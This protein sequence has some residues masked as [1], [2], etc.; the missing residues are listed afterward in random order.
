MSKPI[1]DNKVHKNLPTPKDSKPF[2]KPALQSKRSMDQPLDT[3]ESKNEKEADAVA[4]RVMKTPEPAIPISQSA[5]NI[6]RQ[7]KS[8]EANEKSDGVVTE[9]AG[10]VWSQLNKNPEFELWKKDQ[11]TKLKYKLWDSQ[12]TEL[13]AGVVGFG[14]S[15]VGLLGTA[16]AIDPSFRAKSIETLQG[17]NLALPLSLLPHSEYLGLSGFKYN[18]PSAENAQY[19]FASE[20]SLTPFLELLR[21]K[22]EFPKVG[23]DL[24][25]DSSYSKA[26]GFKP[27]T[28]GNIKLKFG[29]GIVDVSAFY[30][31]TLPATPVLINNPNL[32][33]PPVWL[34]RSLPSQM[35]DNLP[36]GTGVFIT[37]D[38][39]RLPELFNSNQSKTKQ[40]V[41]RKAKDNSNNSGFAPPIVSEVLSSGK[42]AQLESG[43]RQFM[44]N[45]F[46]QD[47]S[48]VR[49]HTGD[50]A[51]Q[52]A[53]AIHANAYTSGNNI[54][55]GNGKFQPSNESGKNLLAHELVHVIQQSESV[56]RKEIET[57]AKPT[58]VDEL[59]T[60]L[61]AGNY[62]GAWLQLNDLLS[63]GTLVEK[64]AWLA[65]HPDIRKLFLNQLPANIVA[66]V[67][68]AEE[69][70]MKTS[71][72]SFSLIDCW[73]QTEGEKE[74]LFSQ[75]LPLF[76]HLLNYISP[77][78]G[79]PIKE[80]VEELTKT[81]ENK[82]YRSS[83]NNKEFHRIHLLAP[84]VERKLK[85]Y[86][87][88]EKL[89][90][91]VAKNFDPYT[92]IRM[93][94]ME[95]LTD[96]NEIDRKQAL[97]IYEQLKVLPEEQRKAFID[98]T[99][100]SGAVEA[101]KDAE[102][103]YKKNY[104]AQYKALPHNWD[105]AILPWNWSKWDAPF[106][107]RLTI[108][109]V[110]LMS[111]ALNYEDKATRKFGFDRG[112]AT[113]TNP[114]GGKIK[115]DAERL[116]I[117]I[118]DTNNFNDPQRL[119]LLLAIA[120]RGG[121]EKRVTDRI[122]KP[123]NEAGE[124]SPSIVPLLESY[125][126]VADDGFR[127][128]DDKALHAKHKSSQTWYVVKKTLFGGKAGKV[129]GEQRGTFDLRKL[130]D[131]ADNKGALGGMKIG[132]QTH[133]RE[134]YYNNKWLENQVKE[135]GASDTLLPNL[136][137]T[138]GSARTGKIFA[139][140]HNKNKQ[141]NIYASNI[142]LEGLNYFAGGT[143]YRSGPGVLQGL[144]INLSWTKDTKDP[145]NSISLRLNID[146]IQ[147]NNFQ[148]IASKSTLAI[149]HIGMKGFR[150]SLSQKNLPAAKGLFI[151]LFKNADFMLKALMGLMPNALKLLPYA[152][153]T[154]TEEFKGAK[155]HAY[156]DALGDLMKENF[157]SFKSS[158][159]F[160]SL[161]VKNL[162][163]TT[164]GFLDDF[165]IAQK[166]KDNELIR[167]GFLVKETWQWTIDAT[168]NIKKRIK[169]LERKLRAEKAEL[170]GSDS[171][172]QLNA[173]EDEKIKLLE[174][175]TEK[176]LK[177]QNRDAEMNRLRE[178]IS[179]TRRLSKELD[180]QFEKAKVDNPLYSPLTFKVLTAEI[181]RLQEDLNYLDNT[182]QKDKQIAEGK[183]GGAKRFEARER[184]AA[185]EAKYKSF[186]VD[187][188]L[189]GV[190]L[191]GG[192]YVRDI[193]NDSLVS[194]GF[195]N[196]SLEGVENINIGAVDSA[197]TVS[198]KGASSKGDKPGLSIRK[199]KIPLIKAPALSYKTSGMWI[200]AGTPQLQNVAVS[201]R[202]DFEENP[203]EKD[204]QSQYKYKLEKLTVAYASFTGLTLKMGKAAP[205]LNFKAPTP[206]EVWGLQF[207]NFDPELGNINMKIRD[208]KAEG[209]YED[210]DS[211]KKN[212]Q[213]IEFGI[214][215][216]ID[217]ETD[218]GRK[219]AI[220]I[221]YNQKEESIHTLLNIPS[222][223]LPA[224]NLQ[225]PTMD[226]SSMPN[227]QAVELKNIHADVKVMMEQKES[228][229]E[230]VRPASVEIKNL[231]I[232]E[233]LAKGIKVL[234]RED[235]DKV[236]D[237]EKDQNDNEKVQEVILP[238]E[239]QVSIR[240]IQ[241]SGL[242]LTFEEQGISLST[243]EK[244]ATIKLGQSDLSGIEFK[245]RSAKG[246]ILRAVSVHRG[247]FDALTLEAL[248]RN[249]RTYTL[250]EFF[251]FFGRSRL[252]D[253][254]GNLSYS[255]GKRSGTI[256]LS[257]K[258]N[259]A[260]SIDYHE[261]EEGKSGYYSM[262]LP[263][264]RI[265]VPALHIEMGAHVINIP[266]PV[267]KTKV[268]TLNDVDVKLRAFVEFPD[269]DKVAYDIFLDSLD[270]AN[271]SV[272]GLE[273]HHKSK[274]ID[275]VFE[276][277][278]PL[279]IPNVKAGGF[280]FSSAKGFDVFG[281]AGCWASAA[282]GTESIAASLKS[283]QARI[284]DGG[285]LAEADA[286]KSA[287]SL[288]IESMGFSR[289]KAGN[290]TIGLGKIQG[291]FPKM[292]ITQTDATTGTKTE[293]SIASME[294][295]LEAERV[296]VN[297]GADKNHLIDLTG[298]TAGGLKIE[299]KETKGKEVSTTTVKIAEKALGAKSAQVKLNADKS[300]EITLSE[301]TGGEI[302]ADL[303]SKDLKEKSEK[304][305]RL[306]DPALI[307]VEAVNIKI[308]PEGNKRITI[309]KPTIRNFNLRVPSQEKSGDFTSIRCDL[310]VDG[311]MEM[312]DGIFSTMTLGEPS[313]AFVVHVSGNV[314]VQIKNL[315]LDYKD[316]SSSK[317][318]EEE[319]PKPLNQAQKKLLDLEEKLEVARKH[320]TNTPYEYYHGEHSFPNPEWPKA[321]AAV[322]A[323]EKAFETQ[324]S[325]IIGAARGKAQ[326]SMT[327][328]YLDAVQGEIQADMIA[329]DTVIPINIETFKG[330]KYLE[331]SN[332]VV[333]SLKSLIT[334]ILK[335]TVDKDFWSS[336]DMKAI[337]KGLKR[338]Y[339]L[340]TPYTRGLINAIADG[341]GF[342]AIMVF[343]EKTSIEKGILRDDPT[344]F[345]LN[346]NI[347]TSYGL[348]ISGYDKF[349]IGLCE[350]KYKHP[351]KDNYY[352]LY[353]FVEYLGYISPALVSLTGQQDAKRAKRLNEGINRTEKELS[354][355][356]IG[357][358]V[359]EMIAFIQ[360]SLGQE[361]ENL[362]NTI[363]RNIKG[364]GFSAD[365]S[366]TPQEVIKE[367]L[368]EKK[369][370]TFTF[371]KGDNSIDDLYIKGGYLNRI[372]PKALLKLGGGTAG[373]ENISIPG[374]TY[375]SQKKTTKVSY[376][377]LEVSPLFLSYESEK[378]NLI[379]KNIKLLGLKLAVKK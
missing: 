4:K 302:S 235:P 280:R 13:K 79:E 36:K 126:F 190:S 71:V 117:Q 297:L 73:Y 260:I 244:D 2:F 219:N 139:S 357:E 61:E 202:I 242:K 347:N 334:S 48:Q 232:G 308:D 3:E 339:T 228:L 113:K 265:N 188:A 254:D 98:V 261:L 133:E 86:K 121:L 331:I 129:I 233:I 183:K 89:F 292:T 270:I 94:T 69:L 330:E 321:Y 243:L 198:G 284:T 250:K 213:K 41:Q 215:T 300:K 197:Y 229:N 222:V 341:N 320:L 81:I 238:K 114:E 195:I 337:G 338:W 158:L 84:S 351:D 56:Q 185:I 67:Y 62:A 304:N 125:G 72:A 32:G 115:N 256:G 6:Q 14:L 46:G 315:V 309:I 29:A 313:D 217:N 345:G 93:R 360:F 122:L 107:E 194:M 28:G 203:L 161:S 127:Y 166:N 209:L 169:T 25:L 174:I 170:V 99:I 189:R 216:T 175:T 290:M 134:D 248:G 54:V 269:K 64:K 108:D 172:K 319:P 283:I 78:S 44:E 142:P 287:L 199:L 368:K 251:K 316:T 130:Q 164:G 274:G 373:K 205:L 346:F 379:N 97:K 39:F 224:I 305:I 101:D 344:M 182:Y 173:L 96:T 288:D 230:K 264:S 212:S 63:W 58:E 65:K 239:D 159:T 282:D 178:I 7:E 106:A 38:V 359:K 322:Q 218:K 120:V 16:F 207:L 5:K 293:I 361:S 128:H 160:T 220:D 154:M 206:V 358:A 135:Q 193:I 324:K 352:N 95:Y 100:F 12:P 52:S 286:G 312:G 184:K 329:F 152:V 85:F 333:N 343:L 176:G 266:R 247:K 246:S 294:K 353:G 82:K 66:E 200:E 258:K 103:Y 68:S 37:V 306:P 323:A 245:E 328:K 310:K 8:G 355:M 285:F 236:N 136:A 144:A 196:P 27:I 210:K 370:G 278:K 367:L 22:W 342:G 263:L 80:E 110:D 163:D 147:L 226:I 171:D 327:K 90:K 111:N 87:K 45:R 179:E 318:A 277:T 112:I 149:G 132:N 298:L 109:H 180:A 60:K 150:I 326:S 255:D 40:K 271:M 191:T 348:D 253:L 223:W 364:V 23:L 289:D 51:T 375:I 181:N 362:K 162:Y 88:H 376:D 350:K 336:E 59:R 77:Y 349:S 374:A 156:K 281:K 296:E 356:G 76:D 19:T 119:A 273:Y 177:H 24:G 42:G 57:L 241:V 26:A 201:L 299:S 372:S 70:M 377:S 303:I 275:V 1:K 75:Y 301:I 257:G 53:E 252:Q 186:E 137:K 314:P 9:G 148:L 116:I 15:S 31:Q 317:A 17:V 276:K 21:T 267:N 311:N 221:K 131:T 83:F 105:S 167:Q 240:D 11:T 211:E 279:H 153:M 33:E 50:K 165:S 168:Q 92:G 187:M 365:I 43:T 332:T 214:D 10:I 291:G 138:T 141:A 268:S 155:D 34:M 35:D 335:S 204:P 145:D 146:N 369:A 124:I 259:Q 225:S 47:F 55:F 30:N 237:E 151:G 371:D 272:Y 325:G 192:G 231:R 20:F 104:K 102:K 49:I 234:L 157:A 249:G 118:K 123:K 262:R 18:L 143:L 340:A 363:K 227:T 354:D 366:L 295:A 208:V 74:T 140:I 307:E 378:Y 91:T